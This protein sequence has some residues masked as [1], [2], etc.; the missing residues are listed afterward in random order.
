MEKHQKEIASLDQEI[1]ELLQAD[2]IEKEILERCE[3]NVSLQETILLITSCLSSPKQE[4]ND[5]KET[6]TLPSGSPQGSF[7]AQNG[8]KGSGVKNIGDTALLNLTQV[9]LPREELRVPILY[10]MIYGG[11]EHHF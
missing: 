7:P 9:T 3:F 4:A 5:V 2:A 1:A 10:P 8:A 11:K 6:M